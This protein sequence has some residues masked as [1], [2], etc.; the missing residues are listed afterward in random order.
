MPSK[1]DSAV[2]AI[3]VCQVQFADGV[4]L[5]YLNEIKKYCAFRVSDKQLTHAAELYTID[6]P[7]SKVH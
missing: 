7:K 3:L 6:P 2:L 4:G 1:V 5:G